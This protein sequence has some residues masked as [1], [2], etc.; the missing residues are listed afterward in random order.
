[1]RIGPF[2][3]WELLIILL[4]VILVFGAKRLPEVAK[5]L[6]QSVK[7]FRSGIKDVKEDVEKERAEKE[8]KKVEG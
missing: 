4:V 7:E 8:G 5:G 6:G 1:M 3:T 2:G